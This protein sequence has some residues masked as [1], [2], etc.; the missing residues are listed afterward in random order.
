MTEWTELRRLVADMLGPI[1][2]GENR[3]IQ[4]LFLRAASPECDA[5]IVNL[6]DRIVEEV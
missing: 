1:E 3:I 2:A 5:D 4:D 6:S